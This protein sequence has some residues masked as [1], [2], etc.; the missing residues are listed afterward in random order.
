MVAFRCYDPSTNGSGGIHVW[1]DAQTLEVRSAIDATLELMA[2]ETALDGHPSFKPLRG[3]CLGLAG[4]KIDFAIKDNK[5][6][7]RV[8]QIHVRLLG[9]YDPPTKEFVLL[10]GFLKKGGSDYGPMCKQAHNR[11]RGVQRNDQKS[12]PCRFP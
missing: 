6:S 12:K 7:K 11:K 4:I 8:R 5:N 1:Y 3:K 9:P 2:V 10:T